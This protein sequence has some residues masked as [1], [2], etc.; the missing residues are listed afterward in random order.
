MVAFHD[1]NDEDIPPPRED[2]DGIIFAG[3]RFNWLN[4]ILDMLRNEKPAYISWDREKQILSF[5]S[6]EN[7]I[8][9]NTKAGL[10][11]YFFK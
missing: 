7:T 2:I 9:E 6:D 1:K 3:C 8:S 11:D 10:L 4:S 5:L